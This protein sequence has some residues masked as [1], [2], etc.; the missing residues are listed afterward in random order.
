MSLDLFQPGAYARTAGGNLE[1]P[2]L[3]K[4]VV[5]W[6]AWSINPDNGGQ[7]DP[8]VWARALNLWHQAGIA[9]F[10]WKHCRSIADVE[11]LIGVAERFLLQGNGAPVI[12]LNIEDVNGDELSLQEVANVV[13]DFWVNPHGGQ[14][15]M[16]TLAWVQNG[17]GW[18]WLDFAVAAL[19]IF[20][21]EAKQVFPN[22]YDP[23]VVRDC[24]DHAFAEGLRK[25]TYMFKTK[26]PLSRATYGAEF[27]FC[28]SLYTADD[29]TPSADAWTAWNAPSPCVRL[30]PPEVPTVP[31]TIKQF[32]YTG[33]LYGPSHPA[34]PTRNRATVKGLKRAMIRL[35]YLSQ[36]LGSETDDFGP[37]LEAAMKTWWREEGGAGVFTG[38]GRGAWLMLRSA[39]LTQGPNKGQY[40]LDALARK[41]VQDDALKRC[42]PHPA[43]ALSEIC[44]G[45]H[46]TLGINGNWAYDFC[47][48][49]GTKVV[50]VENAT[51]RKLS[52]HDPS[53]GADQQRGI[54]G[55]SIHYETPGGYRYFSTH[56]GSRSPLTV[57]QRVDCGQTLGTVGHW[58]GDPSRSHTHLG[59][60]SP[61]GE[62]DAKKRITDVR[63]APRVP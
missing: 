2:E 21:D 43:G 45:L 26:A 57:G 19:E 59:V 37:E 39:R 49:G 60:T 32:P 30:K 3:H 42:Y 51:I 63:N 36:P 14:V 20:P 33:P 12:G 16:A 61:L 23:K 34:G 35:R 17:Q 29:I 5:D 9:H 22:G 53:E 7:G 27:A 31:L 24:A 11:E 47:A 25:V 55:W 18:G 8:A 15:H 54:F 46:S 13:L 58:P 48:P 4:P 38:Y 52:G 50:A 6:M 1:R 41:Y 56:Y 10:P 44:Q 62:A 40:A 28:H